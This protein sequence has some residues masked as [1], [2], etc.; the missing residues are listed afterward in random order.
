M[1]N[2][3]RVIILVSRLSLKNLSLLG[4]STNVFAQRV[5]EPELLDYAEPRIARKNLAELVRI[6]RLFGGHSVIRKLLAASA[7]RQEAFTVLDIGAAS[8][9][10]ARVIRHTYPRAT[11]TS[12]DYREVN[13]EAAP[14]PKLIADAFYLPFRPNSFDFVMSSLF[15]HHFT[16]KQVMALLHSF[17]AIA[18]RGVLMADLERHFAPYFFLKLTKPLFGWDWL[19]VHDGL[20]SVRAAFRS[21]ELAAL[22]RRAGLGTAEIRTN[23]PAF[24][25]TL[26]AS[27][28]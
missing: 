16:D 10:T 27:K 23:R 26:K 13:I 5:I 12:L 6:N 8:G 11:V 21:S 28:I 2:S 19:T 7:G 24:R 15:L 1:K 25:L 17:H 20:A 22:A 3:Y 14:Y 9:D 4:S 18:R